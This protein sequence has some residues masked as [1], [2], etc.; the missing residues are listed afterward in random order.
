MRRVLS[1]FFGRNVNNEARSIGHLWDIRD[2]IMQ[3][4]HL[5]PPSQGRLI[6]VKSVKS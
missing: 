4:R 1:A 2:G 5:P 3:D 6:P